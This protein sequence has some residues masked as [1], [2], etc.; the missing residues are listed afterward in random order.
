VLGWFLASKIKSMKSLAVIF[1]FIKKI[2][3]KT[4]QKAEYSKHKAFEKDKYFDWIL[5]SIEEHGSMNRKDIDKLLW[6]VLP[7]WMNNKQRKIKIN[8]LLSELR[9]KGMIINKGILS[10]PEWA[11]IESI[12]V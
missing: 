12:S 10:N 1:V 2:A 5:K 9:K 4:G 11:L 6:N 8:N 7:D 3:Q